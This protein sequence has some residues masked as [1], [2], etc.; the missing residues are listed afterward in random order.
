MTPDEKFWARV[1]RSEGPGVCWPWTGAI[2]KNRG[3]YGC[4]RR[5]KKTLWAHRYAWTLANGREPA[6]GMNICHRCANPICCNPAHLY[7]GTPERNNRD[8]VDHGHAWW[9]NA[10]HCSNGHEWTPD[11][12]IYGYWPGHPNRRRCRACHLAMNERRNAKKRAK[13]RAA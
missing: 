10:T 4:L 6:P 5:K 8:V 2:N 13:R 9:Q 7:E 11:N 12:T 3:G 1:D